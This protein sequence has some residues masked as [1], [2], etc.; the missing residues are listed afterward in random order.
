[1]ESKGGL[2]I[3]R[4]TM[5]LQ[6][7][8]HPHIIRIFAVA[9]NLVESKAFV[10]GESPLLVGGLGLQAHLQVAIGAGCGKELHHHLIT[11]ALALVLRQEPQA[12]DLADRVLQTAQGAGADNPLAVHG[13][14]ERPA[15]LNVIMLKVGD[16]DQRPGD[17]VMGNRF[18]QGVLVVEDGMGDGVNNLPGFGGLTGK[19]G[20]DGW[21]T[22]I[23]TL[24]LARKE[25]L[26]EY[27]V[28]RRPDRF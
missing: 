19:Q 16:I 5:W 22:R 6:Y 20:N 18:F 8:F 28:E 2:F 21:N 10:K 25:D 12:L 1:M 7:Q 15:V 17:L 23:I 11:K 27:K 4:R 14:Q 24:G 26:S 9:R 3:R 13:D